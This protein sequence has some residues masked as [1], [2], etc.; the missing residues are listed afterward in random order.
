MRA[1]TPCLIA[2]GDRQGKAAGSLENAGK[3]PAAD[4]FIKLLVTGVEAG[5]A[6]EGE[7]INPVGRHDV[8]VIDKGRAVVD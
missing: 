8:A 4:N 6:A 7:F 3:V 1:N 2:F 5:A